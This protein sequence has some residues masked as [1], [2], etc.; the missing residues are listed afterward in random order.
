MNILPLGFCIGAIGLFA[1]SQGRFKT[2]VGESNFESIDTGGFATRKIPLP[3]CHDTLQLRTW[4]IEATR[5]AECSGDWINYD[6][7]APGIYELWNQLYPGDSMSVSVR[8]FE[9]RTGD[10]LLFSRYYDVPREV[11]AFR[12]AQL[13]CNQGGCRP[14]LDTS[15]SRPML[16]CKR[17]SSFTLSTSGAFPLPVVNKIRLRE[18]LRV[19]NQFCDT[20]FEVEE[21][22]MFGRVGGR[23]LKFEPEYCPRFHIP[24]WTL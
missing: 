14:W 16:P 13:Y 9:L 22:M 17:D 23:R 2:Y 3:S 21:R 1:C 24:P 6:T 5:K 10:T 7:P 4:V 15:T 18:S 20:V 11:Q 8:E 19:K 12:S